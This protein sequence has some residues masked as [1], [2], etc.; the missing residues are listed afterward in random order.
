MNETNY[1]PP[2]TYLHT[3][4]YFSIRQSHQKSG[5]VLHLQTEVVQLPTIILL[6]RNEVQECNVIMK[7]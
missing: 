3:Y 4:Y 6:K 7:L 1:F 5:S 2:C